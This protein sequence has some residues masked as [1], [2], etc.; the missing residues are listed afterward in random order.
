MTGSGIPPAGVTVTTT[1]H[2]D[3]NETPNSYGDSRD[4]D[5]V[6]ITNPVVNASWSDGIKTYYFNMVGFSTDGGT[7]ITTG[8]STVEGQSNSAV[9]YGK[10]TETP[11]PVPGVP[12][13]T[14]TLLLGVGASLLGAVRMRKNYFQA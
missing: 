13:P 2:I 3:H 10:I 9:L 4:N 14:S 8:W 1:A 6:T 7:H 5:I 12:E 11:I